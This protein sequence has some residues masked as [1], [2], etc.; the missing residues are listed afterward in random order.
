MRGGGWTTQLRTV[1]GIRMGKYDPQ[2]HAHEVCEQ[3][4]SVLDAVFD[5]DECQQMR[6]LMDRPCEEAGGFSQER[7]SMGFHPLL[8]WA[9][10]LAPFYAH[11]AI[12]DI[13]GEML[14]DDAR[15]ALPGSLIVDTQYV[16]P[17]I[18][19]WHH[20]HK[21]WELPGASPYAWRSAVRALARS[22]MDS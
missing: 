21:D 19:G 5:A 12:S 18:T 7:P 3:G 11:P 1:G 13:G 4:Y 16:G 14:Q 17:N 10:D 6:E 15:L 8:H 2:H 9:P 22:P 20:H